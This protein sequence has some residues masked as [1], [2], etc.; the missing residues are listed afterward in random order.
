MMN[1]NPYIRPCSASTVC[2]A[3]VLYAM[4][5]LNESMYYGF[6]RLL[7]MVGFTRFSCCFPIKWYQELG[8]VLDL[9]S[10]LVR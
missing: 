5:L 2:I 3:V 4:Y 6:F 8:S 10:V 9:N 7:S 1:S